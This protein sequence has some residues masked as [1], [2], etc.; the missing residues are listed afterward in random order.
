MKERNELHPCDGATYM[1]RIADALCLA[2][3]IARDHNDIE[4][5]LAFALVAVAGVADPGERLDDWDA[6]LERDRE[7]IGRVMDKLR[8]HPVPVPEVWR[9]TLGTRNT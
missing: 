9:N 1:G 8:N 5:F 2:T 4:M 6:Q 3:N 7:T